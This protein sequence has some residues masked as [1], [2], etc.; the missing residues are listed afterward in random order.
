MTH[1]PAPARSFETD[2]TGV[3]LVL[4][5]QEDACTDLE[6]FW[7]VLREGSCCLTPV[8]R[9]DLGFR[10]AGQIRDWEPAP[11]PGPEQHRTR[12]MSRAALLAVGAVDAALRD[13]GLAATD[14]DDRCVLMGASL[15]YALAEQ[16]KYYTALSCAGPE[17]LRFG[18]WMTGTAP[19]V[20][21]TVAQVLGTGCPTLSITGSCNVSTRAIDTV[22]SLFRAGDADRVVLVGV[23]SVLDPVYAASTTATS[24]HGYRASCLSDDPTR[25]R[26]HDE[27]QDGNA[28]SEG[29]VAIV[30]EHPTGTAPRRN[31]RSQRLRMHVR[32]SRSNGPSVLTAGPPD[33]LVTDIVQVLGSAGRT[34]RDIAFVNDYADGSRFVEDHFCAAIRLLRRRTRY[35]GTLRLTN[36][37]AAFGHSSGTCGLVKLLGTALML[38]QRQ[39][40]PVTNCRVPYRELPADPVLRTCVPRGPD[41]PDAGLILSV[42][43][44]GDATALLVEHLSGGLLV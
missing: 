26:P 42:G 10:V 3:G 20:L 16:E 4:P 32:S 12:R 28:V 22:A 41:D 8:A 31:E 14:L 18:Y 30:L 6:D 9:E 25:I 15:Q 44:G 38:Q 29:A 21:G 2:L 1:E 27:Q 17:A 37:E 39:I 11:L 43:A 7:S 34:L 19:S 40:A 33:G 23:D 36:Q 35:A 24:R 13:A 5:G